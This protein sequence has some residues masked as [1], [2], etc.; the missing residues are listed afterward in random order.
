[1]NKKVKLAMWLSGERA[2]KTKTA[3]AK[4]LRL[5]NMLGMFMEVRVAGT[6][7][8]GEL[9]SRYCHRFEVGD[10]SGGWK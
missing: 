4:V 5:K 1:M 3:S 9:S 8:P 10:G 6:S 2:S 7:K